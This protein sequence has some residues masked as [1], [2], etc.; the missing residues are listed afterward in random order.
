V[1][2]R[3]VVDTFVK[4]LILLSFLTQ[5]NVLAHSGPGRPRSFDKIPLKFED[6]HENDFRRS[7]IRAVPG[8]LVRYGAYIAPGAVLMPSFV[9]IGAHIGAGTMIDTW[10]TV[11]SCAQVGERCHISGGTGLGGVLEHLRERPQ[12]RVR[13]G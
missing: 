8:A 6:W 12:H 11:G 1:D 13:P 2:D 7:R 10:A 5:P 9:N 4:K 3:W